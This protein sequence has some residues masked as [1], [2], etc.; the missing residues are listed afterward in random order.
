[1]KAAEDLDLKP[2][3]NPDSAYSKYP[4]RKTGYVLVD[5]KNSKSEILKNLAHKIKVNR[6]SK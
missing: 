5:K 1:M 3:L 2:I 4:W 6:T